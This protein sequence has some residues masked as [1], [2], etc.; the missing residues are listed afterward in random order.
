MQFLDLYKNLPFQQNP[1]TKPLTKLSFSDAAGLK[2]ITLLKN[3]PIYIESFS[4]VILEIYLLRNSSK[5]R[6]IKVQPF[7]C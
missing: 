6:H 3:E 1:L 2:R 5:Q 4:A 7:I